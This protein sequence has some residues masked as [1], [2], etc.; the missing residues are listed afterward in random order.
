MAD[1]QKNAEM[2]KI[3]V[4]KPNINWIDAISPPKELS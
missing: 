2:I 1:I 4:M 3:I